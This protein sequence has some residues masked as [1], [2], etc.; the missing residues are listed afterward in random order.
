M[1]KRAALARAIALDPEIL[2]FDEPS[3]GLDPISSSLLDDLIVQIK[4][5]MGATVVMVTHE[6]P[7]IFAIANNSVYLDNISR[8]MIEYGNPAQLR[9][10]SQKAVV[11]QFLSRSATADEDSA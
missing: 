5:S 3:A 7:S 11:R 6:L 9:D 4:E 10:H 2:F 8:T 1:R